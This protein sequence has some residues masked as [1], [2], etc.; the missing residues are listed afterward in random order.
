NRGRCRRRQ[1]H[2]YESRRKDTAQV[3]DR[4]F[5]KHS[6]CGQFSVVLEEMRARAAARAPEAGKKRT[7]R[8]GLEKRGSTRI[9]AR[10][11]ERSAQGIIEDAC[12]FGTRAPAHLRV[13][14][15]VGMRSARSGVEHRPRAPTAMPGLRDV[16]RFVARQRDT[17]SAP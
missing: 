11:R 12:L 4:A 14:Y 9:S 13:R 16:Q 2:E 17:T 1:A 15:D 6:I 8:C 10:P 3:H 5:A 7:T